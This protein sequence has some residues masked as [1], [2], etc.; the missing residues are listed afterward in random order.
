MH[1]SGTSKPN[2][3][4]RRREPRTEDHYISNI[5]HG[6]NVS[7][8][9]DNK[10]CHKPCALLLFGAETSSIHSSRRYEA[11]GSSNERPSTRSS[12]SS[13][14]E[15]CQQ[16]PS[17]SGLL[18]TICQVVSCSAVADSQSQSAAPPKSTDRTLSIKNNEG[19]IRTLN[20]RFKHKQNPNM[21]CSSNAIT[22]HI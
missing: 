3:A 6:P 20:L 15:K 4:K 17:F 10:D 2:T 18:L 7:G 8:V 5:S 14:T 1:T 12:I 11:I 19:K 9:D 13:L 16:Y 21:E 22:S